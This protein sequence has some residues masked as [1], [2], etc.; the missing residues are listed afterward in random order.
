MALFYA[1]G[2]PVCRKENCA[3]YDIGTVYKDIARFSKEEKF[4]FIQNFWKPDRLFNFPS[5]LESGD[6]HR[7]F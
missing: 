6:R 2:N 7:K 1:R 3:P 4:R 5:T